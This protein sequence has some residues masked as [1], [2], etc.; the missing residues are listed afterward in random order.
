MRSN[1]RSKLR[2]VL[3]FFVILHVHKA[4]Y[5]KD[6]LAYHSKRISIFSDFRYTFRFEKQVRPHLVLMHF[7]R[8]TFMKS[9]I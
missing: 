1:G 2:A 5:E 8:I 9:T 3:G 6:M 4:Y 7:R